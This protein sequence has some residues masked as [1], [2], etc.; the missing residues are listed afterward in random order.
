[1]RVSRTLF[2]F[3][4]PKRFLLMAGFLVCTSP[5]TSLRGAESAPSAIADD[6]DVA[7]RPLPAQG[8]AAHPVSFLRD[9]QPALTKAGCNM[10]ACHGSLQGRGGLMLSLLGYD[11][12]KD[13]DA[14][15]KHARGRRV[16]TTAPEQSLV[17]LKATGSVPHG[18]GARI[19]RDSA[20]YDIL[21]RYIAAG[22]PPPE[23][24]LAAQRGK[25]NDEPVVTKLVVAPAELVLAPGHSQ[26]IRVTAVWSDGAEHDVTPW[27]LY[28]VRDKMLAEVARGGKIAA[29][30]SGRVPATVRYMGQVAAVDVTI[31]YG[32][33]RPAADFQPRGYIDEIVAG[34]WRK[35]GLEP[36]PTCDDGEFVRRAYFDL[37]G[38]LPTVA[39][40][41]AFLADASAD[42]RAK[43]VDELLERPEYVD[44]WSLKW[45]DLLRVHRRYVG[46]KGLESFAGWVRRAVRE[47]RPVDAMVRELLTAQG[48]LYTS[49]PVAFYMIDQKPEELAETTSQV[50]LGVR[51][52]C[53]KCHHHPLE[54]WG[55]EDYYGLAAF[56]TKIDTKDN[57]DAGRYGGARLV[58]VTTK[59]PKSRKLEM[60]MPAQF[61]DQQLALDGA[62]DIRVP[63]AE[64]VTASP[65]FARNFANR[66]W[67]Y[68]VG[69]GLVEPIDDVRATNPPSIPALLDALARD[70]A[71]HGYDTKHML[72]TICN[73]AVYQRASRVAPGELENDQFYTHRAPRRLPAEVLLDAVNRA[74]GSADV[75]EG[76]P[77]G[78]RA[79]ALPDPSI[80][81]YFLDL[82]GRPARNSGC[83]CARGGMPDLSQ[84]LHLANGTYLHDKIARPKG[85]VDKLLAAKKSRREI[86]DELYL[87]TLSRPPRDD[88]RR[89]ID[90][91]L[92]AAPNE[93]E[94]YQDL[95]WTLINCTEFQFNH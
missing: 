37:I 60:D 25:P 4:V 63:L 57:K 95:L 38:T 83:E 1:M 89:T 43:L 69:R 44:Y 45:S 39:E 49:G 86:V 94:G 11:T 13:Y 52:Q 82:F 21:H 32:A 61:F 76:V 35:L 34:E 23:A 18:G 75:Y 64:A 80:K 36:A 90:Q 28:D 91:L 55:Q 9:V 8:G 65:L 92:A 40:V 31:P 87:A 74:T 24:V 42:K 67:A 81:S 17:L 30:K 16:S 47:N 78:T 33:P 15:F 26:A 62:T 84:A 14:L 5:A 66:Y 48:N 6:L 3:T 22:C 12:A 56:F 93:T 77:E 29:L 41:Q 79:I 10:G 88:E 68:L 59:Q 72:R 50:F 85:R 7:R 53:T 73:S 46:E 20:C 2:R 54:V 51:L 70:F 58:K 27:A 19:A 71:D